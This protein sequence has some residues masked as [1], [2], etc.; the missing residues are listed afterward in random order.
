MVRSQA[1]QFARVRNHTVIHE[2]VCELG[3][4]IWFRGGTANYV[5]DSFLQFFAALQSNVIGDDDNQQMVR[6]GLRR[7][8]LHKIEGLLVVSVL[9][10]ELCDFSLILQILRRGTQDPFIQLYC[11]IDTL[12]LGIELRQVLDRM[13]GLRVGLRSFYPKSFRV[14]VFALF[15]PHRAEQG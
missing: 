3:D 7:E 15:L 6:P 14:F 13:D 1:Q 2:Y 5:V 12:F 9:L 11:L 8:H 4:E 10:I